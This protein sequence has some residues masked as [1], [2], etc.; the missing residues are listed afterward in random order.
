MATRTQENLPQ[1]RLDIF[2]HPTQDD[3]ERAKDKAR[4]L[5]RS[6]LPERSWS[7]LEAKGVIQIAG[8]RGNYVIS[9]Y[10][11]TEIRDVST[12]RCVA[13][14]CLQLSIPAPTYDRMVAEYLLIKNSEEVYWKTANIFSRNGNEFGIATLFLV[15]FDIALF[16]NLLLEV[17]SIR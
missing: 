7:E 11:Q 2:S 16:V 15:A 13:Y 10:S 14:A 4:Q 12:G 9:P 1:H 5:L 6:I 17:L 3:Y 8:K